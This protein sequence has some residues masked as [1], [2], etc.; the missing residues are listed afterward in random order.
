[1]K[2]AF[3]AEIPP[4][5]VPEEVTTAC[6]YAGGD[7]PKAIEDPRAVPVYQKVRYWLPGWVRSNPT[8]AHAAPDAAAFIAWLKAHGAPEGCATFLDLEGAVT[9]PYVNAYGNAMHMAGFKVLPYTEGHNMEQTPPLDGHFL[10]DPEDTS[11]EI[12][13][14]TVA[15]QFG[16]HGAFDISAIADTVEL[17]EANPPP[18]TEPSSPASPL[19]D[20]DAPGAAPF[21]GEVSITAGEGWFGLPDGQTADHVVGVDV[22]THN[23]AVA[24]RYVAVPAYVGAATDRQSLVFGPGPFGPAADGSYG[25]TYWYEAPASA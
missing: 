5:T 16:Y 13:P 6:I 14:G 9:A 15:T 7:T 20:E 22:D 8:P 24:G 12:E 23:P 25:F 2:I 1:M 11:G 4:E 21:H 19:P 10:A 17:W 3:D 18:S